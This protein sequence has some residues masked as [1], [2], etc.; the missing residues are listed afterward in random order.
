MDE[1]NDVQCWPDKIRQRYENYLKTSFFFKDPKLRASF[2]EALQHEGSLL[3][4]PF[5]EPDR[6]F[7][8]ALNARE[9][10][11]HCFP[12]K[13]EGLHPALIDGKL[14]VHQERAIRATHSNDRNIVVA[15]GTASGKTESFLYPILFDLYRQHLL[16]ELDEPGVRAMIL[17]P[18]NA[19][20]ND[21]RERLG[22][23]CKA[24][25][26][27]GS[28]FQ[29]TFG[30]YIGQTPEH[31]G[32]QR[33]NAAAKAAER[34][35]NELV[36]RKEMRSSPPHILLTNYSMLEYL[37][38]RPDD[39]PL[40]DGGLGAH[41]KFIVL[42][43]AH[44]Y[45]G[46]KGMEMGMLI[47]R[48]K[49]RLR[50]GGRQVPFRCIATSATMS[51][52]E[53]DADKQVVAEFATQLF[54]EPFSHSDVV[55]GDMMPASDKG[56]P[57]RYHAFI[58]ALEGAFLV[59]RNAE[60]AVVLNRKREN[61]DGDH[62]E[63]LEIA[64]CRECGQHYYVGRDQGGRLVEAVRDPSLPSFGVSYYLPIEDG[65]MQ[66]C[67]R[68]G[69]LSRATLACDCKAGL[70]VRKCE[71]H[72]DHADQL[73]QCEACG[74][75]RGGIGDPVQ[76]IVHGSDGPN[77]VIATAVHELLPDDRRKLLAFADSRQEA[78]FFAW[79][80]ENSYAKLR[81]RNL[82]LRAI[83]AEDVDFEGLSI[84]DLRNRL[85]QIWDQVGLLG[86]AETRE[87]RNRQV[88]TAILREASTE[89]HRLSLSGVGLVEWFVKL[90][91][92]FKLPESMQH[93]PWN[94]TNDEA[95]DLVGHL[96]DGLLRR[97]A[98][99]L[100]PG[101][102]TP[103]W[104]D[105]SP[106]PRIAYGIGS[107]GNRRNVSQWGGA[108]SSTVRHFL[109]RLL[110]AS[111]LP[112]HEQR[113]AAMKLMRDV[114]HALRRCNDNPVLSRAEANGTF[115]LNPLWLRIRLARPTETW[116]CE[117]CAMLATYNIRGV[118]SRN[119]CPGSLQIANQSRLRDNHYRILY[120]SSRLPASMKAEEHTAQLDSDTAHERQVDFKDGKIHLLSSSTTFEVGVDLGDLEA[121]FLRN[122]P[123]EP[124]NYTQRVGR[125]GRRETSG[126]A[127]TYCRRN[128]HDL[129]HYEDPV[130]RVIRGTVHPP[131]LR[132][133][134]EKIILRHMVATELSAF[135]RENGAR[136]KKVEDFIEDW[137]SPR[138]ASD[139]ESY[140]RREGTLA[141]SLRQIVPTNMHGRT[142]LVNDSWI[143]KVSGENSRLANVEAEVCSDRKD[144]E[145]LRQQCFD[146]GEDH[147]LSRIRRRMQTIASERL[148]NLLSRKAVIR[149]T[150]FQ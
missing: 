53:G 108:Q 99:N 128:P 124:F 63:P 127:V 88:L 1:T 79:Y 136:F 131:R 147:Y 113:P 120:E 130:H 70:R 100:P 72:P 95:R 121:V 2:E 24:L 18:M 109:S 106:W 97:R 71:N 75:R 93:A 112:V 96:L 117:T 98:I 58:R 12:G 68:C 48:L 42:D 122:V 66:L 140:C 74:Y 138:A 56:L 40:F 47:R 54:G 77:S 17:Y 115:R 73:E 19:L 102:G 87:Q 92:D 9:L 32:D 144:L 15:T 29:P 67:R 89:E 60:D 78:A 49:Q 126:L 52:A 142:G 39:S 125:A 4:G 8:E 118:C 139:L 143:N 55:F 134:N 27:A 105:V 137:S 46:A 149:N 146:R 16:G 36:F 5:G 34:W 110:A 76:E 31:S 141:K 84:E 133:T 33:R 13:S 62:G 107:P 114:W 119:R 129:Y 90:P 116:E 111:G 28:Q 91:Q 50:E 81:D 45:R 25:V 6:K 85:L 150:V 44:Q 14:W 83:R 30:Q 86:E 135:F 41:W 51:S 35:P 11:V 64:L 101:P 145:T 104:D 43:E 38:I 3:K 20:A 7:K 69:A 61:G 123:P 26:E 57:R 23:I 82:L 22:K 59:H 21:Q 94:F 80:A 148:L 132:M 37:L 10:A 103:V 65:D